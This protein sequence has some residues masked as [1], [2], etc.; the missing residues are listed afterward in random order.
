M[1]FD[2]WYSRYPKKVGKGAAKK[3]WDKIK[4]DAK[5]E[6]DMIFSIG[7]QKR[8]KAEAKAAGEFVPVWCNPSTWLNEQRWE[9]EIKSHADLKERVNSKSCRCGQPATHAG[10]CLPCFEKNNPNIYA[11]E[12]RKICGDRKFHKMTRDEN[13]KEM[14]RLVGRIGK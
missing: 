2:D 8:Y 11:D 12:L 6:E 5:M 1:S 3:A 9:D 7:A 13:F 14:R 10:L 4:P